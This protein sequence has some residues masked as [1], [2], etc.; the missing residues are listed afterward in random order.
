MKEIHK[1]LISGGK[2][3]GTI[4]KDAT[5]TCGWQEWVRKKET[6]HIEKWNLKKHQNRYLR[7]SNKQHM[8]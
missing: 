6:S 3:R 7:K 4:G 5:R 1:G 8:K 2:D